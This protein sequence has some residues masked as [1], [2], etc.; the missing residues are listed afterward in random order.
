[1]SSCIKLELVLRWKRMLKGKDPLTKRKYVHTTA[2]TTVSV[3]F[4]TTT[5]TT[6]TIIAFIFKA[7]CIEMKIS[8]C[9]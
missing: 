3:I 1:M 5:T 4:T 2:N 6:T 8:K 9:I 7:K